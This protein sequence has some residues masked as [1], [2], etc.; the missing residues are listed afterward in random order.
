MEFQV[1][2]T[3]RAV[4]A[5][6]PLPLGGP[7]HR[8]LLAALL[9]QPGETV[10]ADRLTEALWGDDPP[11]S[12]GEMIHVRVSELRAALRP[13][14]PGPLSG[15]GGYRLIVADDELDARVFERLFDSGAEALSSGDVA[16]ARDRLGEG[17]AK[18]HGPAFGEFAGEPFARAEAVRLEAL[19]LQA[20]EDR[21]TADL[22]LGRHALV[23][24]ELSAL[25]TDHPLREG[26]RERLMLALHRCG[27][28]A[29]ALHTYEQGRAILAEELGVDPAPA[30]TRLHTAILRRD[31]ALD[32]PAPIAAPLT[33]FVGRERDLAGIRARLRAGRLV[34]LTGVGGAGKSRLAVEVASG[35]PAWFVELAAL[36]RASQVAPAVAAALRVREHPQRTLTSLIAD[37]L[38]DTSG[39]LVLDNCEHLLDGVA[40]LA[41][42]LLATC[43]R[44][45]ILTTGRE[46]LGVTGEQ[47]W[48]VGGLETADAVRLLTARV[49]DFATD[50]PHTEAAARICRRLDGLPLAIELAASAVAALG[51]EQV[52]ER[53][54]DR[55][56]VL[57]GESRTASPRHRT[58]RAVLD[59]SY[60]LL[61]PPARRLFDRLGVF[62]GGFTLE[63][64]EA[65]GASAGSAGDTCGAG[66]GDAGDG[67]GDG[68]AGDGAGDGG[69]GGGQS[70]AGTLAGLVEKSLVSG[71]GARYRLL[72]TVRAYAL[73]HTV[74]DD[75]RDRH[76][77]Y[78]LGVVSSA[79]RGLRGVEE[80][81]WLR[82]LEAEH[83]NIRAALEWS[84]SRGDAGTAVRLAGSLY[85]LWDRHGHY[86]EGREWLSR[87]LALRPGVP[88]LVRAR[89]LDS[90]AGLAVI[91]GDFAAGALA[92]EES[93][94]LSREAGDVAGA[95]RALTTSGLAA[96]YGGDTA[97]AVAV[98]E[99]SVRQ[100]RAAG[101]RG[102]A[103]FAL[104]YLGATDLA[105]SRFAA[106]IE[107]CDEGEAD[108]LAAGNPEGLAWIHIVRSGA[109]WRTGDH[110]GGVDELRAA[111]SGFRSLDH[112]WG[113]SICLQ[114][115][116]EVAAFRGDLSRTIWLAAS[117]ETARESVAAGWMPFLKVWFE[118][119]VSAGRDALPAAAF[120][121]AWRDG[122]AA[123]LDAA[124]AVLAEEV[125]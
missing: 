41:S 56:G 33:S 109:A 82:R 91:Q 10:S 18:W 16:L 79:R 46:H 80:P 29:E 47:L 86:R 3:V 101:D 63:A 59:W 9:V 77:A 51:A 17:L 21:L 120:D 42:H 106:A 117:A 26:L 121:A 58:L 36:T 114:M 62:V 71:D 108:L 27:R 100:A 50:L 37:R 61:D 88:P 72:E 87:A 40:T 28:Q 90:A 84:L 67:A 13:D 99:E 95:A 7:R 53:M 107:R 125:R 68:D 38:R 48:P 92:A 12:A 57:A 4:R 49:A 54:G 19:R 124:I 78:T 89:A 98:L 85:P 35:R 94:S 64:A 118:A 96:F 2:G 44:L 8:R 81:V 76:A 14:H 24:A 115:G 60:D 104:M 43:P 102:Q 5:G 111:I 113:L 73:S 97:R 20:L 105:R 65:V 25:V 112:R 31:P 6:T 69:A 32:L 110:A 93:A 45:R 116:A 1:L 74:A 83:G 123:G 15:D 11:R 55:F 30:A 70:V 122:A 103:G 52:A 22:A 119:L 75:V 34:T 66:D 23:V 39:L